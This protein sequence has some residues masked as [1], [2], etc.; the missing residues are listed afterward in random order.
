MLTCHSRK[1]MTF[2]QLQ[3]RTTILEPLSTSWDYIFGYCQYLGIIYL[4]IVSIS[5]GDGF[6]IQSVLGLFN[7]IDSKQ[8]YF[9]RWSRFV[10]FFDEV[11]NILVIQS[12]YIFKINQSRTFTFVILPLKL[13]T[14]SLRLSTDYTSVVIFYEMQRQCSFNLVLLSMYF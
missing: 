5:G 11:Q 4:D 3:N 14:V 9:L 8:F 7:M 13:C 1:C 10:W 12:L 2:R 6:F